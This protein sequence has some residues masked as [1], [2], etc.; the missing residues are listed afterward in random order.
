[1]G[2]FLPVGLRPRKAVIGHSPYGETWPKPEWQVW[3]RLFKKL[4]FA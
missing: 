4:P 1:M 3:I 2:G